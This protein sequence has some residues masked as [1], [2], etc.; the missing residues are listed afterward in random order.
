MKLCFHKTVNQFWLKH[1]SRQRHSSPHILVLTD[2]QALEVLDG[3]GRLLIALGL[4]QL[5]YHFSFQLHGDVARQ[6]G[7]EELLLEPWKYNGW[8]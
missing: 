8:E 1:A 2:V 3:G 6:H 5:P 4:G 7:K